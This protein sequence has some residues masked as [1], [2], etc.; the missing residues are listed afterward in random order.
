M[1]MVL[2]YLCRFGSVGKW[3]FWLLMCCVPAAATAGNNDGPWAPQTSGLMWNHT[4]LPAVFPLQ[5]KTPDGQDYFLRLIDEETRKEALAAYII[6][7]A[8]FKVL[9]PPGTYFLRF[10]TGDIWQGE[11]RLF[12]P[13]E[14]TRSFGLPD[15]LTFEIR[16]YG[17][18]A[19]RVVDI[20]EIP[21]GPTV[22][23]TVK[24]QFICQTTRIKFRPSLVSSLKDL[25]LRE[26]ELYRRTG[27]GGTRQ[28]RFDRLLLDNTLFPNHLYK[29]FSYPRRVVRSRFC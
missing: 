24:E 20:A 26:Y 1:R 11:D 22:Q 21:S 6:G 27:I 17:T 5:V 18:K 19:G 29:H 4:G 3:V 25:R 2:T 8:F 15:P 23:V 7:G 10:S 28:R 13:D 12:G 14:S 9:V 16:D